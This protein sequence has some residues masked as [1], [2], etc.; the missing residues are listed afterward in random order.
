VSFEVEGDFDRFFLCH[1]S[2]CRKGTG[3]AHAANLFGGNVKLNWLSG[4][5]K[6][7]VYS[8]TGTRH[9]RAFC[10]ECGSAAPRFHPL[11]LVVP[12][13]SLDTELRM[14]PDAHICVASRSDWDDRL[15]HAPTFDHLPG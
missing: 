13:G 5:E 14:R 10:T 1:C 15:E 7:R 6:V 3:S 11:G 12:A 9:Q 8:V 4:E 2:R